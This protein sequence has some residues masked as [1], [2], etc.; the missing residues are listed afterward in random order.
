MSALKLG[1]RLA[2][3]GKSALT[4]YELPSDHL[5]THGVVVGM[6][7]S[8]KTGL[9]TVIIEEAL[10]AG[11]PVLA[12]DVKGDLPN[13]LLSFDSFDADAMTPWVEA[14]P[15]DE[16][17]IA[18]PPIVRAALD[19]RRAGLGAAGIGEGELGDFAPGGE[20][21][22]VEWPPGG[23]KLAGGERQASRRR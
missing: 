10:Q 15:G 7:G 16:D 9:V 21:G 12:I 2:I 6:T 20:R 22:G 23:L 13:L 14:E 19:K 18:D 5:L 8:G 1:Q 17:G 11:V 4:K 3:D